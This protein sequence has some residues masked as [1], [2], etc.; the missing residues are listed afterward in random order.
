VSD[1]TTPDWMKPYLPYIEVDGE[2]VDLMRGK[3]DHRHNFDLAVEEWAAHDQVELLERL[4]AA[5]LLKDPQA[6]GVPL[7]PGVS[8]VTSTI[9][10]PVKPNVP[11]F[12]KGVQEGLQPPRSDSYRREVR[13]AMEAGIQAL[14]GAPE[15]APVDLAESVRVLVKRVA[16]GAAQSGEEAILE[17]LRDVFTTAIEGGVNLWAAV[18]DYS[19]DEHTAT[20]VEMEGPAEAVMASTYVTTRERD[21]HVAELVEQ[22]KIPAEVVH[23]VD[24]TTI[25]EGMGVLRKPDV[26]IN[27]RLLEEILSAANDLDA[28]EIDSIGADVIVQLGLY[29]EIRW[30]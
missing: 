4:H 30:G 8:V 22:G 16:S 5:G 2:L 21:R 29:G 10:K 9:R 20:L 26:R 6:P 12:V 3:T 28:G 14:H 23:K 1:W 11:Y 24:L 15:E 25:I 18:L 7:R 17:F 13:G 19:P 27:S